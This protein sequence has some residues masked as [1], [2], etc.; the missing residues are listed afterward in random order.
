MNSSITRSEIY[1]QGEVSNLG[2]QINN[3]GVTSAILYQNDPNPFKSSTKIT[4]ELPTANQATL[5]V[6][7]VNGKELVRIGDTFKKGLHEI[8]IDEDNF[9]SAGLYYYRLTVDDTF[10]GSKKMMLIK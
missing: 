5:I 1:D 6:Y 9:P 3:V 10:I 2:L 7:N 8:I 4:F